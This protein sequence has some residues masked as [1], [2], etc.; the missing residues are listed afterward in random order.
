MK[1]KTV[2][3]TIIILLVSIGGVLI[4]LNINN[5]SLSDIRKSSYKSP[6]V[7][8]HA[9]ARQ[10]EYV[11]VLKSKSEPDYSSCEKINDWEERGE[12]VYN[13]VIQ[14]ATEQKNQNAEIFQYLSN[15]PVEYKYIEASNDKIFLIGIEDEK[16]L[17]EIYN[18]FKGKVDY[19]RESFSLTTM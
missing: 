13:K 12:C 19:I 4:L 9:N 17:E 1:K 2:L 16:I 18:M 14:A 3:L 8:R 7:K 6:I 10:N 5:T 15:Q 11:I